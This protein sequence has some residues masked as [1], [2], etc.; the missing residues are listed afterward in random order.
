MDRHQRDKYVKIFLKKVS[1]KNKTYDCIW[2]EIKLLE[3]AQQP[4][5]FLSSLRFKLK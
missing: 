2:I 3:T 5:S 1:I 4:N